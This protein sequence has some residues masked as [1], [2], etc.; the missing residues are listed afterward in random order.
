M[1][2]LDPIIGQVLRDKIPVI[3]RSD[4]AHLST[5]EVRLIVPLTRSDVMEIAEFKRMLQ[6]RES[7]EARDSTD[8]LFNLIFGA[9]INITLTE[10]LFHRW[11]VGR[12]D[13]E[14]D[15]TDVDI[16]F[17]TEAYYEALGEYGDLL[18]FGDPNHYDEINETIFEYF[19][20][21]VAIN[22]TILRALCLELGYAVGVA[23]V[24]REQTDDHRAYDYTSNP[25]E[26]DRLI[27]HG[28]TPMVVIHYH[29]IDISKASALDSPFMSRDNP[30]EELLTMLRR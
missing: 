24:H 14:E 10:T 1:K 20:T 16:N 23:S 7:P 27:L 12:F 13:L 22:E 15:D 4:Q 18:S 30:L 19:G 2:Q 17:L 5:R 6:D 11:M 3:E 9:L 28:E 21:N 29:E 26:I 25:V 8:N